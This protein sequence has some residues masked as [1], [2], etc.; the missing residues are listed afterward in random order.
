MNCYFTF[1]VLHFELNAMAKKILIIEDEPAQ[2]EAIEMTLKKS[3][4]ETKVAYDGIS[5]LEMA[6]LEK[7]DL[8]LLDIVL[9]KMDGTDVLKQLRADKSTAEIPILILTNLASGDTVREVMQ[10]GGTE[11]LVKMDYTLEQLANK[12]EGILNY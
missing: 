12:V 9:P 6:R 2:T 8:I 4:F 10:S 5:G 3:G 1:C 11:Y 7:P